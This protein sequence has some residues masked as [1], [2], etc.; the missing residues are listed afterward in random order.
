MLHSMHVSWVYT[1]STSYLRFKSQIGHSVLM[2][3]LA[4]AFPFVE[5]QFLDL[6]NGANP[7]LVYLMQII[8]KIKAANT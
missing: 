4:H 2:G 8:L 6:Q 7:C 5:P 3:L 1:K